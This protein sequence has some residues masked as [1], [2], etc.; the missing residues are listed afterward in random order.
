MSKA[1]MDWSLPRPSDAADF[2]EMR[3][4]IANYFGGAKAD[5]EVQGLGP[6]DICDLYD[7]LPEE[8][9]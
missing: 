2:P 3:V 1:F 4:R 8:A 7:A 6:A 5:R 9:R